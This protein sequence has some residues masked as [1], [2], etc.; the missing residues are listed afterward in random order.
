MIFYKKFLR[1]LMIAVT[2]FCMQGCKDDGA[3]SASSALQPK[4]MKLDDAR[5]VARFSDWHRVI[6]PDTP[7]MLVKIDGD[8]NF[9]P[10]TMACV[11]AKN[12]NEKDYYAKG[13]L[14]PLGDDFFVV[15]LTEL[16]DGDKTILDMNMRRFVVRIKDG[17]MFELIDDGSEG[18]PEIG[19]DFAVKENSFEYVSEKQRG[20]VEV[21]LADGRVKKTLKHQ[22]SNGY[23]PF[24]YDVTEKQ[25]WDNG[26]KLL[27][28]ENNEGLNDRLWVVYPDGETD[29][30]YVGS[31]YDYAQLPSQAIMFGKN[32]FYIISEYIVKYNG[33]ER[34]GEVLY[35][36]SLRVKKGTFEKSGGLNVIKEREITKLSDQLPLEAPLAGASLVLDDRVVAKMYKT[37]NFYSFFDYGDRIEMKRLPV[38]FSDDT[39]L[40]PNTRNY[41]GGR[42]WGIKGVARGNGKILIESLV[43][44]DPISGE[45][46]EKPLEYDNVIFDEE[47]LLTSTPSDLLYRNLM[48]ENGSKLCIHHSGNSTVIDEISLDSPG[49]VRRLVLKDQLADGFIEVKR[50]GGAV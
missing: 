17:M 6:D 39:Y 46:G 48:F 26:M 8:G 43:W 44:L 22:W 19:C 29:E 50:A 1:M 4:Y 41:H 11:S 25:E 16:N 3:P 23:I 7:Y 13:Y 20:I 49:V 35:D 14:R 36:P 15:V 2:V 28:E 34:P 10:L 18:I 47:L 33:E 31:T 40:S 37:N 38:D 30:M 24:M 45:C 32:C 21:T 12:G 5:F 42:V 27:V 9:S